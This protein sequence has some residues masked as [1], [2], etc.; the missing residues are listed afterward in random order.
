[1][2]V[3]YVAADGHFDSRFSINSL[4]AGLFPLPEVA[5]W[6]CIRVF[7]EKLFIWTPA[8]TQITFTLVKA[9]MRMSLQAVIMQKDAVFYSVLVSQTHLV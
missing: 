4:F 1:M 3:H 9:N 6:A 8:F 2:L 7:K 5:T